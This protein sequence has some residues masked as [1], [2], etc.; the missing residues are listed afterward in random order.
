MVAEF[1]CARHAAADV[2]GSQIRTGALQRKASPKALRLP[3]QSPPV[4]LMGS[5]LR[6][7]GGPEQTN[8]Q[9]DYRDGENDSAGVD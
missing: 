5:F 6:G 1:P 9:R 7:R 3:Q 8:G 4:R 2:R